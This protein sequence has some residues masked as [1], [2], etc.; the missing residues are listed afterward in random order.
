MRW[1]RAAGSARNDASGVAI[2]QAVRVAGRLLSGSGL[3]LLAL[4]VAGSPR[5]SL[6]GVARGYDTLLSWDT[7]PRDTP[8]I[9]AVSDTDSPVARRSAASAR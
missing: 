8:R 2:A 7:R 3:A 4:L 5:A 9:A 6:V 1:P